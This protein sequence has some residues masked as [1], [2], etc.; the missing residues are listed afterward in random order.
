MSKISGLTA[1]FNNGINLVSVTRGLHYFLE[2]IAFS[3]IIK[4]NKIDRTDFFPETSFYPM[5]LPKAGF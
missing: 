5:L 3:D 4:D 1:N 2:I